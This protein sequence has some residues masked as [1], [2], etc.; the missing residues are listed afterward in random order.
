MKIGIIAAMKME[1][2]DIL[3]TL[4]K[5]EAHTPNDNEKTTTPNSDPQTT[6]PN[7][8]PQTTT[9]NSDTQTTQTTTQA[10]EQTIQGRTIYHVKTPKHDLFMGVSGV[11][12]VNAAT[13]SQILIDHCGAEA[14]INTGIAG[15]LQPGLG[16]L[17][18]VLATELIYHDFPL[19]ILKGYYPFLREFPT[20]AGLRALAKAAVP[21]STKV[22]EGRIASGDDFIDSQEKK[23]RIISLTEAIAVD[24]ESAAVA[25]TAASAQIPCL[26]VRAI[27]DEADKSYT[28]DDYLNFEAEA[29]AV[30]AEVVVNLLS[31]LA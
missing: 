29:A 17:S 31:N 3:Q 28:S 24:M 25:H 8:T 27:S 14:L 7:S 1:L 2:D 16:T 21:P 22:Y 10:T 19:Q 6:T 4:S 18:L 20:D 26:I 15:S 12:K 23:D 5:T 13:F 30:S 9:P 11:G